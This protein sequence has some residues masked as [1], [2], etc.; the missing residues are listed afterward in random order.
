[1]NEERMEAVFFELKNYVPRAPE[2]LVQKM[3]RTVRALDTE[4]KMRTGIDRASPARNHQ[5]ER[6][7][8][9]KLP[10]MS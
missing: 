9:P 4:R 5:A 10:G 6:N 7:M 2:P 8:G 3:E 1:M